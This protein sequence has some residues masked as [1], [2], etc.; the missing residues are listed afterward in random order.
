MPGLQFKYLFIQ[1][2]SF[3]QATHPMLRQS[4]LDEIANHQPSP[5]QRIASV[6]EFR[7]D[8]P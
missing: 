7:M 4:S 5:F 6:A 8:P 1:S 3:V 2:F